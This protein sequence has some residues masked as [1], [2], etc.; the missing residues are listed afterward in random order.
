MF[1]SYVNSE[2][3]AG[4]KAFESAAVSAANDNNPHAIA[5][6]QQ[7]IASRR[8]ILKVLTWPEER[9]KA[10]QPRELV[11]VDGLASHSR[12]GGL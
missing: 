1:V 5:H 3:G 7:I 10:L 9:L 6:L 8:E 4:G 2:W 12:R 11:A